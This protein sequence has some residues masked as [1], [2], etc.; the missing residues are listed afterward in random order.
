MYKLLLVVPTAL[1]TSEPVCQR[2]THGMK[3][4]GYRSQQVIVRADAE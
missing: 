2:R 3:H 1:A 4:K